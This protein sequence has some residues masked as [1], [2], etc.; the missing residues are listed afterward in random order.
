MLLLGPCI[1]PVSPCL[2]NLAPQPQPLLFTCWPPLPC[3]LQ[4]DPD[5]VKFKDKAR[6]KQRQQ[7][8]TWQ[9]ERQGTLVL[10]G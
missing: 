2:L 1:L 5:T 9:R 3:A 8:R 10:R 4:V 7:V 6:E